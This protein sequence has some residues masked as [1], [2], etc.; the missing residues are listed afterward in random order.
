MSTLDPSCYGDGY[1]TG[2]EAV[3]FFVRFVSLF[4]TLPTHTVSPLL[5][6]SMNRKCLLLTKVPKKWLSNA[7]ITPSDTQT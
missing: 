7:G 5:L 1:T 4:Q 3:D 2:E 6:S